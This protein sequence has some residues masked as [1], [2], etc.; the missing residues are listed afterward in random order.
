MPSSPGASATSRM[1]G[2]LPARVAATVILLLYMVGY[3]GIN[4]YTLGVAFNRVVGWDVFPT[5]AAIAVATALYATAERSQAELV[6]LLQDRGIAYRSF[7]VVNA[8]RV[9]DSSC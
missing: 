2:R 8:V 3:I 5:A 7:R 1:S 9:S 6:R 4:F